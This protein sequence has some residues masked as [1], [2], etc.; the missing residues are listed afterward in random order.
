VT[1]RHKHG[2]YY[3]HNGSFYTH[4][5]GRGYRRIA[6]PGNVVFRHLP[7]GFHRVRIHG[8]IYYR[9][10]DLYLVATHHGYMLTG[11]PSGI[12]FTARW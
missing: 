10:G 12:C 1:L 4:Y 8:Q 7:R 3:Y 6:E 5:A 11:C 2:N 9:H